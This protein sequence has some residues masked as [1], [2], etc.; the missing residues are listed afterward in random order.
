M[1]RIKVL[2]NYFVVYK[3]DNSDKITASGKRVS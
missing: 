2:K 1:I 3:G